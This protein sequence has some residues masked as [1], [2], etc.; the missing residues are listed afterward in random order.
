MM[1]FFPCAL[2]VKCNM[3]SYCVNPSILTLI[4]ERFHFPRAAVICTRGHLSCDTAEN[5]PALPLETGFDL[6]KATL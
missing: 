1:P 2:P 6:F 5:S 3:V 4:P